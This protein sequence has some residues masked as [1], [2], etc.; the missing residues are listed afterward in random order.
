MLFTQTSFCS[1]T[2]QAYGWSISD[3]LPCQ[4]D[5]REPVIAIAESEQEHTLPVKP[6]W[7]INWL[8][9]R[10]ITQNYH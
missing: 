7:L 8:T 6:D 2:L 1:S 10:T 4:E 5:S 3:T 9:C